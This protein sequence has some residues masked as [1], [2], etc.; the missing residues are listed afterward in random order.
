MS[1]KSIRKIL[2]YTVV[3]LLLIFGSSL[4]IFPEK[5]INKAL[6]DISTVEFKLM[7][8]I[9]SW[10]PQHADSDGASLTLASHR[11]VVQK[12]SVENSHQS[13]QESLKVGFRSIEIDISF[14]SDFIPFVFHGPDLVMVGREGQFS[15]FSSKQIRHFRLK[16]GESILTLKEF[17]HLYGSKFEIV[18]LDIKADN[19]YYKKKAGMIIR[20]MNDYNSDN[21]VLIGFPWRVMRE[22]K[23]ALP[24]IRIGIEQKGAIANFLLSGNMVSLN[25]RNE[26]SFAE[27][28]LAKLLGLDVLTW[29]INDVEILK[30]YSKIFKMNVLTDLNVNQN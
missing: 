6:R 17:C 24:H 27:Y 11:G 10:L 28:K 13:I 4:L 15:N 30:Q 7:N 5:T 19:R 20:E 21:I 18:Y 2:I 9:S 8:L 26:F 16:N 3:F 1:G 22:V 14:S 29:T 23:G 12:G 25:Y